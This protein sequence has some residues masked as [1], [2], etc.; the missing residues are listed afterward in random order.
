MTNR[1]KSASAGAPPVHFCTGSKI[2]PSVTVSA[3][4]AEHTKQNTF[5]KQTNQKNTFITVG[6]KNH[7]P[8]KEVLTGRPAASQRRAVTGVPSAN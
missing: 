5:I 2:L 6:E 8:Y 1:I 4:K 3:L 7:S